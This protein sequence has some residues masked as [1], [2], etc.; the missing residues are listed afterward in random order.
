MCW[1][2]VCYCCR[3]TKAVCLLAVPGYDTA[4]FLIRHEEFVARKGDQL[5]LSKLGRSLLRAGTGPGLRGKIVP[6]AGSLCLKVASIT[7][8]MEVEGR[9]IF[10]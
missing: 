6:A 7:P 1:I 9:D 3:S 8:F 4:S 5:V 10:Q 2:L